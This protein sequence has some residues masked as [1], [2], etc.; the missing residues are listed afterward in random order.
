MRPT[1]L[2][3]GGSRKPRCL[4]WPLA[5]LGGQKSWS[6]RPTSWCHM[7]EGGHAAAHL[8]PIAGGTSSEAKSSQLPHTGREPWAGTAAA[9][10]G[11]SWAS[12][13]PLCWGTQDAFCSPPNARP[14][15]DISLHH[16]CFTFH[17]LPAPQ[18]QVT[19]PSCSQVGSEPSPASPPYWPLC[20]QWP[21]FPLCSLVAG[22]DHLVS[23][24]GPS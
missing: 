7:L 8:S 2:W 11:P 18:T 3:C 10:R 15:L 9:T 5:L 17:E 1:G 24:Q 4:P 23:H 12:E 16:S 6:A 13:Q 21:A 20:P 19:P 14:N 22:S